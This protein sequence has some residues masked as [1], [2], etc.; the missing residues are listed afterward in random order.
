VDW[1]NEEYVKVYRRE[2]DDD[3]ILTWQA[4]AL[5]AAMLLK[6]DRA[7]LLE[8]RRGVRGLAALVRIPM[9][10]V[11]AVLPELLEDGRVQEVP[12]G[13]FAPNFLAAQ[14][15]SKS[16]KLRQRESRARRAALA[17]SSALLLGGD[18][19]NRDRTSRE[20]AAGDE[21][22]PVLSLPVG[23]QIGS[24][25]PNVTN[26][27]EPVTDRDQGSRQDVTHR[28]ETSRAVT[29]GHAASHAVTLSSADP[30]PEDLSPARARAIPPHTEPSTAPATGPTRP[31]PGTAAPGERQ[32]AKALWRELEQARADAAAELG[33][34]AEPLDMFDPGER[35]LAERFASARMHGE[36]ALQAT[37]AQGRHV[38]AVAKAE[39][40]REDR[41]SVE[42]LTGVIFEGRNW[43][44]AA[45]MTLA[46]AQQ[47]RAGP[48]GSAARAPHQPPA[49]KL[50]T[51][52]TIKT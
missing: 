38:I 24:S 50:T 6:F 39:A 48:K 26:R 42:W 17:K 28:D 2:T 25:D 44:R 51:I 18:V 49:R 47:P 52:T 10:V 21:P 15:A 29:A 36:A 35:A 27:D 8:T 19:T 3:L 34:T 11:Q 7:G 46:D 37:V 16:D 33:V 40:L 32:E 4:R 30:D 43:R 14:E 41:R 9:D 20:L 31:A 13:Y 12:L 23:D 5:W 45:G 22:D 1:S